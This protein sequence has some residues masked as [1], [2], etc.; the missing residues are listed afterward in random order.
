MSPTRAWRI[1]VATC[2]VGLV[3][4][5]GASFPEARAVVR[6][7][8]QSPLSERYEAEGRA[9][10]SAVK[11]AVDQ[12]GRALVRHGVAVEV[13]PFDDRGTASVG[14]DDARRIVA[15]PAIVA[16]IGPLD[17]DVALAVAPIYRDADLAMLTPSA[18][19]PALTGRGLTNVFR[20]CGRDDVQT[21]LA[22]RFVA[23][24]L[25]ARKVHVV[26]HDTAYGRGNAELFRAAARDRGLTIVG[27]DRVPIDADAG[28][29]APAIRATAPDVLYVAG[30]PEVAAPLFMAARRAGVGAT[31][32]GS[33]AID[34]SELL[35]RA[36]E[37]AQGVYYTS[38]AGPVGVHPQAR[39]FAYDYR[40][41]FGTNPEPFAAQA[42]DAAAIVLQ[43]LAR[44]SRVGT[45]PSR[46]S[47]VADLHDSRYMGLT[48]PIAFDEHGDLRRALYLVMKVTADDP[49]DWDD[50]R[51]LK[52]LGLAPPRVARVSAP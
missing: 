30:P 11:L 48:G 20:L 50:N 49:D 10:M 25:R 52:R 26:Y 40:K 51:E 39:G 16:V 22:A 28:A 13:A 4:L 27:F 31:F 3:A 9:L 15:D 21:D 24:S 36:G 12:H 34:S 33:D 1:V 7:A 19:H 32:V 46:Q 41:K 6:I 8:T 14:V 42:Y 47:V 38:V 2:A 17:S 35:K 45:M 5:A 23:K 44:V 18:T 29:V 37:A 43:T